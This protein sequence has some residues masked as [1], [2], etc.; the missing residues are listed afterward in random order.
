V[1]AGILEEL[2]R[3]SGRVDEWIAGSPLVEVEFIDGSE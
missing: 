2:G 1:I 3:G